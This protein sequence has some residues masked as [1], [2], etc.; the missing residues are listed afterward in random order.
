ML[1]I[2]EELIYKLIET[3]Y[4]K[5]FY[6]NLNE[7]S[8][9]VIHDSAHENLE[10]KKEKHCDLY[11]KIRSTLGKVYSTKRWLV[12]IDEFKSLNDEQFTPKIVC[13][14]SN[15]SD[16]YFEY[17]IIPIQ[18]NEDNSLHRYLLTKRN[19]STNVEELKI[20]SMFSVKDK[21]IK[22]AFMDSVTK[23]YN[24][25]YIRRVI[26]LLNEKKE[27]SQY[28]IILVN[29]RN[30][31]LI[32]DYFGSKTGD[33][34]L[35]SLAKDIVELKKYSTTT[36]CHHYADNFLILTMASMEEI[37]TT[38][39][40][41]SKI[42]SKYELPIKIKLKY[43]VYSITE[44]IYDFDEIMLRAKLACDKIK[45]QEDMCLAVYDKES[46]KNLIRRQILLNTFKQ[47]IE[48]H[49]F[50]VYYQPI[51]DAKTGKIAFAEALVRWNNSK[52]GFIS[53]G[54]FIPLF[55]ENGFITELDKY[56]LRSVFSDIK[57][58]EKQ[59]VCLP[60]ISVNFSR[61]DIYSLNFKSMIEDEFRFFEIPHS[62]IYLEVTE[63]A[64]IADKK[65]L[66]QTITEMRE[67]GFEFWMDDFGSEYS[68]L[69][70]LKDFDVSTLKLDLK[71]FEEFESN[72]KSKKIIK[73]VINMAKSLD[74][75][76]L[77]EGIETEE[78]LDFLKKSNCDL[79][80]GYIYS[81]PV[82]YETFFE[83][84]KEQ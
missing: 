53:P 14:E 33:R 23:I 37:K 17:R 63:S 58:A 55:E 61:N 38:A 7:D 31:S 77:A 82:P 47:G 16:K 75:R 57:K 59:G 39:E 49:E 36:V 69:S 6:V 25:N 54:E 19:I 50:I 46:K 15:D 42:Y 67:L 40:Q 74:I 12:P 44:E 26:G 27:I 70:A 4:E 29:I 11:E 76:I 65:A 66:I 8:C 21:E 73:S 22:E 1:K 51:Y 68:T 10:L 13:M 84:Y 32:N 80:Q 9:V 78:Q 72:E 56:V 64:F 83:M 5:V 71:F 30:F 45:D 79:I 60:R 35:K 52:L 62:K 43:G 28:S 2:S 41:L 24:S 3:E 18:R 34:L 20:Q 48:N 81:K